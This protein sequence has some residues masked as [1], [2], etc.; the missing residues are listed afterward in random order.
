MLESYLDRL[1]PYNKVEREQDQLDH[2]V[3]EGRYLNLE[4]YRSIQHDLPLTYGVGLEGLPDSADDLRKAQVH[5]LKGY[6]M[7]FDQ[8]LANY[9]AQLSH[10]RDLYSVRRDSNRTEE[11]NRTYF[12]QT[13]AKEGEDQNADNDVPYIEELLIREQEGNAKGKENKFGDCVALQY[14][15]YLNCITENETTYHDRRNRFL[16]HLL[17]RFSEDFTDYVLLMYALNGKRNDET[18]IINDKSTFLKN[19]DEISRNR[20]KGYDQRNPLVWDTPN[21]SGIERRVGRLMGVENVQRR[22]LSNCEV[23]FHEGAYEFFVKTRK[24]TVLLRSKQSYKDAVPAKNDWEL[25]LKQAVVDKNYKRIGLPGGKYIRALNCGALPDMRRSPTSWRCMNIGMRRQNFGK[26]RC[27]K[28]LAISRI[29]VSIMRSSTPL[30]ATF[31]M[32]LMILE[33]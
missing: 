18:E 22:H 10:I 21:V 16:D 8:I 27:E 3:P 29:M 13:L 31:F 5:Q 33:T 28:S 14:G 32:Y 1:S 15:E 11:E 12:T 19:Y 2:A 20:G 17:A 4:E 23:F 6:L 7:F 9:L 25:C 24:G 30:G 26:V